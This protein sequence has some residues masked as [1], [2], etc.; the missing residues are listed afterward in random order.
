MRR[1]IDNT[2]ALVHTG[3][4]SVQMAAQSLLKQGVPLA[5]IGRT[6]GCLNANQPKGE[7]VPKRPPALIRGLSTIR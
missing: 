2:L 1:L 6:L 5:V 3:N 4:V 7:N